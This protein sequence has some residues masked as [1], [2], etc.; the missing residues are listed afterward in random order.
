MDYDQVAF[1]W[2]PFGLSSVKKSI[3][4]II[5]A[6]ARMQ[7]TAK[8]NNLPIAAYCYLSMIVICM[9]FSVPTP[10]RKI[11]NVAVPLLVCS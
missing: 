7:T 9:F 4:T 8:Q 3:H 2:A 6:T 10:R 1:H 5:H 11:P